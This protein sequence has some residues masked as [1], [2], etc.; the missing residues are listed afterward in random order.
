M[1]ERLFGRAPYREI[2]DPLDR[3]LGYIDF[4]SAIIAGPIPEFTCLLGTMVQ[5]AYDTHPAIRRACETYIGAHAA[6]VAKD[7]EAAKTLYAP[8]ATW[9][10]ASLALHTQGGLEGGL[11]PPETKP[12]PESAWAC[13]A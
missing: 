6:G 7:I 5:E 12:G 9:R 3:L 10:A 13:G 4:R 1:A 11:R 2:A 8:E